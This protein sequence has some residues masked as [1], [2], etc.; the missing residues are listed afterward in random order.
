MVS[1]LLQALT[2][3]IAAVSLVKLYEIALSVR[4]LR[5]SYQT[6]VKAI[7]TVML[8][9]SQ[10]AH[11]AAGGEVVWAFRGGKWQMSENNCRPG[12]EPGP[13]P[14]RSGAFEGE[15]LRYPCRHR[16]LV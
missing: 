9:T 14:K 4:A 10:V 12:Y 1:I 6:K 16:A 11:Q 7:R 13:P 15:S 5:N 3:A 2:A 8:T